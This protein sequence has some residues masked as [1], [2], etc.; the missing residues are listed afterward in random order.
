MNGAERGASHG[1]H[2]L[3]P[4]VGAL[5]SK[6]SDGVEPDGSVPHWR[7]ESVLQVCRQIGLVTKKDLVSGPV[8]VKVVIEG[9][10]LVRDS[11][12]PLPRQ[13]IEM[14]GVVEILKG[15]RRLQLVGLSLCQVEKKPRTG[16]S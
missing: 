6:D 2:L 5:T 3:R 1:M 14:I 16:L 12:D 7:R 15:G 4:C 10:T 9:G 11:D 13:G 8:A